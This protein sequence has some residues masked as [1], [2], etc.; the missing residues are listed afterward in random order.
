[1]TTLRNAAP[2]VLPAL[3]LSIVSVGLALACLAASEP[4]V[5]DALSYVLKAY[6]FWEAVDAGR[7]FNPF[8]IE[9]TVRPPGTILMAYPFGWSDEFR[10][11][12]FRSLAIPLVLLIAAV[13]I[14]GWSRGLTTR[15][16]WVLAALALTLSGMPMLYQFQSSTLPAAANWGLVDGF[17][18]GVCAAAA[19]AA[20]RSAATQSIAWA[21]TAAAL[22]A[23]SFW[24][25]PAGLL[26]MALVGLAW[27]F[28]IADRA[29]WR[30]ASIWRDPRQRRFLNV[31]LIGAA[32]IFA[33][34]VILASSSAYFSARNLAFGRR[35]LEILGSEFASQISL[36]F[37]LTLLRTSF[38]YVVPI[39][40]L[41]GFVAALHR[42]FA[43]GAAAAAAFCL[44]AGAW[45]WI[46]TEISQVRYFLP[47]GVMA[48]ILLVPALRVRA[49]SL[50]PRVLVPV[51]AIAIAPTFLITA[52]LF[53]SP[54]DGLQRALGINLH[55]NDYR[56]E[57]RQ[58]SALLETLR[59]EGVKT[60]RSYINGLTP[61]LRNMQAVWDYNSVTKPDGVRISSYIPTDWQRAS[62]LHSEDLLRADILAFEPVQ[63]AN[64]RAAILANRQVGD[65][66]AL[67]RLVSAW[68]SEL[69]ED[70]GVVFLSD[71]RV[72]LL[73][74]VDTVKFEAAIV[75]LEQSFDLPA[76]YREAN[77]QRW[78]SEAEL[79]AR[80]PPTAAAIR[81]SFRA[82]AD[83][84][85]VYAVHAV[86]ITPE[87]EGLRA[88][89]WIEAGPEAPP[90]Q[91]WDLFAHLV[92]ANGGI[93]S[94]AQTELLRVPGPTPEKSIRYYAVRYTLWQPEA[95][96][97]AFG[98]FDSTNTAGK[99]LTA[100]MPAGDAGN[101]DWENRRVI[102]P[103]PSRAPS[104]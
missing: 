84:P 23:L 15:G 87:H 86:E 77:P 54:T 35:V 45:F 100:D 91:R 9:M 95:M 7:L 44:A 27:L 10:W 61:P 66:D 5:W 74:I 26:S 22:G 85:P 69:T 31:S 59:A 76:T 17:L 40:I 51:A 29:G 63:D 8:N 67:I 19:A 50:N 39:V 98:I 99:F 41:L 102:V 46:D 48:Y 65:R 18:A 33:V 78:W 83:A 37:L 92:D 1:M 89:F 80:V 68:A 36:E 3:W 11:F 47:F 34:A 42:R 20:V 57:D 75:R 88:A 6:L 71:T 79:T 55:V 13:Y 94:N 53:A 90:E 93:V 30:L 104:R 52:L 82:A 62:T 38:G 103:L 12:Y 60:A 4:P 101:R 70:D 24:I 43:H 32:L 64:A 25:K 21:L 58:A 56:A 28:L 81:T 16:K 72:R 2:V 14:A 97:L 96:S 73:R 49:E